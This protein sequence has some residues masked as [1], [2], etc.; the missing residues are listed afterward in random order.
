[1]A[2]ASEERTADA[3]VARADRDTSMTATLVDKGGRSRR[4]TPTIN[5]KP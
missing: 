1:M 3:A 5:P 2:D 4:V